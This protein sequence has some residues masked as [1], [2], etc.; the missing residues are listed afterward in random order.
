MRLVYSASRYAQDVS[1]APASVTIITA[2]EIQ[3]YGYRTL[4]DVLGAARGIFTHNDR[5]Y[6]YVTV[7]GIS[8]QSDYNTRV[9]LL[10]DGHRL[11]D[12]ATDAGGIGSD[13]LIDLDL[14]DHVEI[15]HGPGSALFGT[16]AF[17]GVVNLVT[18]RGRN[19][20]GVRGTAQRRELRDVSR[21]AVMGQ[22]QWRR[23]LLVAG[24]AE[25]RGGRD[26]FFAAYDDS[27]TNNGVATGLDGNR[28]YRA[29]VKAALGDLSLSGQL[30]SQRS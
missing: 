30:Q 3:R 17:F 23:E 27:S 4:A 13:G 16:S 25:Q 1:E 10:V 7:R 5:A 9:Q 24:S 14:I 22:A 6:E 12:A 29:F 11:N 26:L 28:T 19:L 20:S 8:R 18:K 21:C 15:I 2:D